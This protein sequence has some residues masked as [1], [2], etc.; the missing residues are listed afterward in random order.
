[1]AGIACAWVGGCGSGCGCDGVVARLFFGCGGPIEPVPLEPIRGKLHSD[2]QGWLDG[3]CLSATG[4]FDT[5]AFCAR[6][7]KN[8]SDTYSDVSGCKTRGYTTSI[9]LNSSFSSANMHKTPI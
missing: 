1:M 8:L 9:Y 3:D 4:V 2:L 7:Q 5:L 6:F